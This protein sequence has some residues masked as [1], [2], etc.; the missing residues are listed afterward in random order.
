MA[1]KLAL[2]KN[3]RPLNTVQKR[4]A[5]SAVIGEDDE[6]KYLAD[7]RGMLW[8]SGGAVDGS[9]KKLAEKAHLN[10]RTISKFASGETIRPQLFTVRRLFQAVDYEMEIKPK[11]KVKTK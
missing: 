5:N 9:W 1:A 3:E 11:K 7:L 6:Q 4:S 8:N 2:V 10:A